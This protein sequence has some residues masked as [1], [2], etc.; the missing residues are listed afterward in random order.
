MLS[1]LLTA[2]NEGAEVARTVRSIARNTRSPHEII[3]VD[4]ASTDGSC[5]RL[6]GF[7]V[8]IV[9]HQRRIGVAPSRVAA[10]KLARGD[11]LAFLDAH[12]RVSRGCLDACAD[13]AIAQQAIV[14]PDV[15][16]FDRESRTLHG[17][18]F[19]LCRTRG[20]FTA[21]WNLRQPKAKVS[22]VSSVRCPGYVMP[23]AVYEHVRW[24]KGLRN[25]G[26]SEAAVSLKAFFLDIPILHLCGPVA[27]HLFKR[28]LQYDATWED[29]WRNQAIIARVCFAERTWRDY[30]LPS[31]FAPHLSQAT[32]REIDSRSVQRQHDQFQRI[33][34]RDD[35]EFWTSLLRKPVPCGNVPIAAGDSA[36]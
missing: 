8:R 17:A 20:Y 34:V 23:R 3:L 25:W 36:N 24:I 12:Q 2:H 9:R 33:K 31:V 35:S 11:V 22:P 6:A 13:R 1:V 27:K 16:G 30:W 19:R 26:A 28:R 15:R 4:D 29:V 5:S 32:L 7:R 14:W 21:R 18:S 10:A